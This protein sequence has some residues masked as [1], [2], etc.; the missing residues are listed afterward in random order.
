MGAIRRTVVP[1]YWVVT[2][3]LLGAAVGMAAFYAPT[4]ETMGPVQKVFYLHLPVALN[5]FALCGVVFIG[6]LGYIWQRDAVWD[7][8][9]H[10]AAQVAVIFCSVV[11][12][13]GMCWARTAW[14]HW[15]TWS[16]RLTFSLVLWLLY[17]VYLMVRPSIE[18][19][20]RRALVC[21][22]YGIVAF[23]DVPLV[24]LSVKLLPDIHPAEIQLAPAMQ[25]TL[26]F[27]YVPITM[28][29]VGLIW[30]RFALNVRARNLDLRE[31]PEARPTGRPTAT[32]THA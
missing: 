30:G 27:W 31:T 14:G 17:V 19:G 20:E 5:T 4:E 26:Y 9:A 18:S 8:L 1:M 21:A 29:A 25:A 23:L 3:G 16:P 7:D 22:V 28:L 15:W 32:G 11:L 12:L 6:S 2:L 24:Y 13:T 10:A